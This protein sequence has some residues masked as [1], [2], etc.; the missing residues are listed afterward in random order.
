[1]RK[2]S[3]CTHNIII[4]LYD[5][6]LWFAAVIFKCEVRRPRFSDIPT[7]EI[8]ADSCFA[9]FRSLQEA[10]KFESGKNDRAIEFAFAIRLDP[11]RRVVIIRSAAVAPETLTNV[12]AKRVFSP[13][14]YYVEQS[15]IYSSRI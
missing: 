8:W 2:Y 12:D 13:T 11:R 5:V 6:S 10:R 1:M 4:I 9:F 7:K 15:D 3:R 14:T